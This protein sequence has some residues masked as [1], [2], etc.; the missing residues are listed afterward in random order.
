MSDKKNGKR[1][2]LRETHFLSINKKTDFNVWNNIYPREEPSQ[3]I[4][5]REK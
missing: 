5:P 4:I 2:N 3:I 1:N